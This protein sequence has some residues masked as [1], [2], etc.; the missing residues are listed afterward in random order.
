[1]KMT[2][3][4]VELFMNFMNVNFVNIDSLPEDCIVIDVSKKNITFIPDLTKFKFLQQLDCSYSQLTSLPFLPPTLQ[5]LSCSANQLTSLPSLSHYLLDLHCN[6][7]K[8]TSLSFLPLLTLNFKQNPIYDIIQTNKIKIVQKKLKTIQQFASLFY[9]L[10]YK[11]FFIKW[12]WKSR[13]KQ[14]IAKY[15]PD[16][17]LKLLE[18]AKEDE[19]ELDEM[20]SNW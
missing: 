15:S 8:L 10:K 16:N 13:E 3:D 11:Q 6:N 19:D 5:E 14:I 2:F 12:L 20:L 18:N 17:L 1:M 4:I 7:N 9:S